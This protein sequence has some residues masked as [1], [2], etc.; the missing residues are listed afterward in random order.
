MSGPDGTDSG[1]LDAGTVAGRPEVD[2]SDG[3]P[4]AIDLPVVGAG[5]VGLCVVVEAT[6]GEDDA[7]VAEVVAAGPAEPGVDVLQATSTATDAMARTAVSL[8]EAAIVMF[9]PP[10]DHRSLRCGPDVSRVNC[11]RRA[12]KGRKSRVSRAPA[13][14]VRAAGRLQAP[15]GSLV[16]GRQPDPGGG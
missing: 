14:R 3:G 15:R 10:S 4:V 7:V 6:T 2:V 13:P 9:A 16:P 12:R 11:G 5:V 1:E 8:G